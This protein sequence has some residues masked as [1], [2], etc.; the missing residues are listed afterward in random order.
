MQSKTTENKED[1]NTDTQPRPLRAVKS[2]GTGPRQ[3]AGEQET[4]REEKK[5]KKKLHFSF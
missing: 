2:V 1:V 4:E 5:K 3:L